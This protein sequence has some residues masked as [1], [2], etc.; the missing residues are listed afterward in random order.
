MNKKLEAEKK[1]DLKDDKDEKKAEQKNQELQVLRICFLLRP[2]SQQ[3][4][5]VLS[6]YNTPAG[7]SS[8]APILVCHPSEYL[9]NSKLVRLFQ[10]LGSFLFFSFSFVLFRFISFHNN[11][12]SPLKRE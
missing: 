2:A 9:F 1:D 10:Q 4:R 8:S 12:C 7:P 5:S 3:L 6:K 11:S